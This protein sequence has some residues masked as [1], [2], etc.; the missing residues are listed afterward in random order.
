MRNYGF[1]HQ[2]KRPDQVSASE[3]VAGVCFALIVIGLLGY[4]FLSLGTP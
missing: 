2:G 1:D 4:G 3:L